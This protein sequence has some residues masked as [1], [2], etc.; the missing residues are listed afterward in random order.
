MNRSS[1]PRRNGLL[2]RLPADVIAEV[3]LDLEIVEMPRGDIVASASQAAHAVYFPLSALFS[4]V[5]GDGTGATAEVAS[6]GPE[7]MVGIPV[8]LGTWQFPATARVEIAG[9]VAQMDAVA[10]QANLARH[11]AL[12][13]VIT[14]YAAALLAQVAQ[15]AACHR[16][17]GLDARLARWLLGTAD[18]LGRDTIPITHALLAESLGASRPKVSLACASLERAGIITTARNRIR[19]AD[20]V[21]LEAASCPCYEIVRGEYQRLLGVW[22][23]REPELVALVPGGRV[24]TPPEPGIA[25]RVGTNLQPG[26]RM[27]PVGLPRLVRPSRPDST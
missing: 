11:P 27:R 26:T 22:V 10:L 25:R 21:A 1:T 17:H 12:R 18:R 20:R 15:G 19:I 23:R 8:A 7:G 6:V 2:A 24:V 5:G 9:H 13:A 16:L 3:R 4:I 14:R